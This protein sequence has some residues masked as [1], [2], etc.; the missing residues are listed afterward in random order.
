MG[1]GK[2]VSSVFGKYATFSGRAQRSEYWWFVLFYIIVIF[3]LS[4]IDGIMGN[5]EV[6][7]LGW[8]AILLMFL[9]LLAL[10]VRRLHDLDKS[11]WWYLLLC[12]PIVG[13]F[14]LVFWFTARGTEGENRFGADP[15]S[16]D[17]ERVFE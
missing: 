11:G 4:F 6:P 13:V 17:L 16:P 7:Y 14:F 15:L 1:F 2:A 5:T 10:S 8:G 9:P 3:V 12:V